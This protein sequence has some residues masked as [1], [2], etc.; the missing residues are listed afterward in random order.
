MLQP[1]LAMLFLWSFVRDWIIAGECCCEVPVL[2][3]EH[4]V[5]APLTTVSWPPSAWSFLTLLVS[6]LISCKHEHTPVA[7][8]REGIGAGS[9]M[10]CVTCKLTIFCSSVHTT[11]GQNL[12]SK[13]IRATEFDGGRKKWFFTNLWGKWCYVYFNW[14]QGKDCKMKW[15]IAGVT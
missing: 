3:W 4:S 2:D 9:H 13:E 7:H 11:K 8:V 1:R 15:M 10:G 14:R 5:R 6:L 12:K